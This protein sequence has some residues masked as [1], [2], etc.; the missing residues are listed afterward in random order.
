M[1][2]DELGWDIL[3]VLTPRLSAN[4]DSVMWSLVQ[5]IV[6]VNVTQICLFVGHSDVVGLFCL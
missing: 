6:E 3:S 2:L 5:R 1:V 4:E